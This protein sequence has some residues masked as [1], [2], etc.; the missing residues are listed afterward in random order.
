MT[1]TSN[2]SLKTLAA[3]IRSLAADLRYNIG[4]TLIGTGTLVHRYADIT[5]AE[6]GLNRSTLEILHTLVQHGGVMK[7][8]DL[9]K[10]TFR[11]KQAITKVTDILEKDGMVKRELVGKDRRTRKV[12]ITQ[13]GTDLVRESLS[14]TLEVGRRAIPELPQQEAEQFSHTLRQVRRH[15]TSLVSSYMNERR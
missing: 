8:S 5:A 13:K 10:R 4:V 6:L 11:T 1:E 3:D 12:S 2:E 7:P 15:L 9:S 14:R